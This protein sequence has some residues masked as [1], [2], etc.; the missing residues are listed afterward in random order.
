[1]HLKKEGTWSSP[2][3]LYMRFTLQ[4]FSLQVSHLEIAACSC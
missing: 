3:L 4:K 2:A 1:M